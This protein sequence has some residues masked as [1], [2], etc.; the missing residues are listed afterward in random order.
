MRKQWS[1]IFPPMPTPRRS[2]AC[3]TTEQSLVVAG[4]NGS[5]GF[6]DTVE[7]MNINTK[8]WTTVSPLPQKQSQLSAIVYG[9]TLYLAGGF[10]VVISHQNLS[11]LVLLL[12]Y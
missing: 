11:S 4:G 12:I 7:V 2:V 8:Q 6:L 1:E 9:D 5:G 10:D 3:I